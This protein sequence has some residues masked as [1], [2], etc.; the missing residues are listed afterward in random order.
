VSFLIIGLSLGKYYVTFILPF[1]TSFVLRDSNCRNVCLSGE[2][3]V[4]KYASCY[5]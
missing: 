2:R 5:F 1:L 3:T 4:F